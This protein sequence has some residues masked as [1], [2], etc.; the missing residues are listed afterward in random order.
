MASK[1]RCLD[2]ATLFSAFNRTWQKQNNA[3]TKNNNLTSTKAEAKAGV[4]DFS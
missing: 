2:D 1:V 4:P 3:R